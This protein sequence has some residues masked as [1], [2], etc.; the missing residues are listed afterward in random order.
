MYWSRT[1]SILDLFIWTVQCSLWCGGGWL[2]STHIFRLRSRERLFTGIAS[3]SLFFMLFSNLLA[4]VM[5]LPAAYWSAAVLVLGIG[6]L[7]A[8]LS[9][10]RP[11]FPIRDLFV[12]PQIIA[13][14][15][16]F[17][18]FVWIN[19]GLSIF[20]DYANLP[21][22]SVIATGDVPPHFYLN[23]TKILDYH[24]G[25]HL[26]AA[27]LMRVGGFFPWS[28]LDLFKAYSIAMTVVLGALWYRRFIRKDLAW[29]WIGLVI[30]LGGGSRW[31]LLFVPENHLQEMSTDVQMIGSASDSGVDFY[32]AM[33]GPWSIEGDTSFPFPFAFVNSVSRPLSIAIGSSGAMATMIPFLLLLLAQRRWRPVPGLFFGLL[34]TSL[35]LV[36]EHIFAIIWGGIFLAAGIQAWMRR[37][38]RPAIQWGWT[39]LPGALLAP[40]MGGVLTETIQGWLAR[41]GGPPGG[42][43]GLPQIAVRWP[44]AF[45]S[46]HLGVLSLTDL[47]HWAIALAEIGLLLFLAPWVLRATPGY[48][49]SGKLLMAGLSIMAVISFL[50]PIL[51]RFAERDRDIARLTSAALMIWMILGIP[52]AWFAYQRGGKLK[53]TAIGIGYVLVIL[54]G[55]ALLPSQFIAIPQTRLS[56]FVDDPDALMSKAYWNNLEEGAWIMD[57]SYPF[58]PP[59]LFGRGTGPAYQ[60]AYRLLPEFEDLIS[61]PD[62]ISL[63]RAGYAYMYVDRK[64]W[65]ELSERQRAAFEKACVRIVA[66]Q[67]TVKDF[68]RLF[69]IQDCQNAPP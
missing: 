18:L 15:A 41:P 7:A 53:K 61:N 54:G 45:F 8:F 30:L 38:Y 43:I 3:G 12:W 4:Q 6:L 56:Y 17:L 2:I 55:V 48:L 62:P 67:K 63:A 46:P 50:L 31:L 33:T 59:T 35:A 60:N 58:R 51:L 10:T 16:L 34:L 40:V 21:L 23:P 69:D 37:S 64:T 66:E 11:R 13:F 22:V 29:L 26:L 25:G 44:P 5:S 32:S 1:G 52:Y 24:Y 36:S 19:R 65:Q 57:L 28:S 49:R 68:R 42:G 14:I 39:L 20:D 9:S 27:S 47:D